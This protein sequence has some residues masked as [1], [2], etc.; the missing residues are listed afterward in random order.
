MSTELIIGMRK[1]NDQI[2]YG[3]YLMLSNMDNTPEKS[4]LI[5]YL[6]MHRGFVREISTYQ[7]CILF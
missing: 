2:E 6:K 3:V 7:R 4:S 1:S 5:L